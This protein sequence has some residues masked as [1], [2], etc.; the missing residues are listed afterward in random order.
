MN[1]RSGVIAYSSM[2]SWMSWHWNLGQLLFCTGTAGM[3]R[4][5]ISL[6]DGGGMTIQRKY[7]LP[8]CTLI[9]EGLSDAI[10]R[11]LPKCGL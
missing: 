8:N 11:S 3:Q 7:S 6:F 4:F 5:W 1:R 2:K 9:V 10:L